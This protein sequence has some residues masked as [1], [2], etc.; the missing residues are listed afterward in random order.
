MPFGKS[1]FQGFVVRTPSPTFKGQSFLR[2]TLI[3]QFY[4][5]DISP[6]GLLTAS[7]A[8]HR[9]ALGDY[10]TVISSQGYVTQSES[11][12]Q[13]N[14]DRV[15]I[16][17]IWTLQLGKRTIVHRCLDYLIFYLSAL[18]MVLW[19]PRQDTVICL[20]T[21]PFIAGVGLLH[22]LIHRKTKL[23]LWNMDC[24]PEVAEKAGVIR[25]GGA[26]SHILQ[27]FNKQLAI[28]FDH[29]VCLDKPMQSILTHRNRSHTVPTSIIPNWEPLANF[30]APIDKIRTGKERNTFKI[31]YGGNL[32]HGHSLDT[33]IEAAKKLQQKESHVCFIVTG[34]GVGL[35]TLQQ[36]IAD[37]E[38]RNFQILGYVSKDH[39]RKIQQ[40]ADCGVITLRDEM[41]GIMSPSKLHANLAIGQPILYIGPRG[42][43]VDEAITQYQCGLSLRNGDVDGLVDGIKTL[44]DYSTRHQYAQRSRSAFEEKY[45]DSKTLPLFDQIINSAVYGRHSN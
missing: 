8:N 36:T 5:P 7:L 15:N 12:I 4:P 27:A 21:P 2:L 34:G 37:Q 16:K 22:K 39:F 29:I 9:A 31:I 25:E 41:L 3:N 1:R 44:T 26:I 19:L 30:P 28:R 32:G 45:C 13:N 38:L 14:H 35:K 6:T 43:N 18:W 42:S 10:V 24:Y 20:T 40:D 11:E 33:L 17:R 23:V